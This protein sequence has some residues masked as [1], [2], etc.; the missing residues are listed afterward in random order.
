MAAPGLSRLRHG[1]LLLLPAAVA[2][3]PGS[4]LVDSGRD[5]IP[6]RGPLWPCQPEHGRR[7]VRGPDL[8]VRAPRLHLRA[9]VRDYPAHR[10]RRGGADRGA[11][12][13]A[14]PGWPGPAGPPRGTLAR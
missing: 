9:A 8:R 7:V 14:G 10:A 2:D 11:R 5:R 12:G 3:D 13:A 6:G 4:P 1:V